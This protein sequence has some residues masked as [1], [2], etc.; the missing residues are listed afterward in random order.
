MRLRLDEG[1]NMEEDHLRTLDELFQKLMALGKEIKTDFLK[2]ANITWITPPQATIDLLPLWKLAM[3]MTSALVCS[4]I[5]D[6][7]KRHKKRNMDTGGDELALRE[8]QASQD[9]PNKGSKFDIFAKVK[10]ILS[11]SVR[12]SKLGWKTR[13]KK[14]VII[15]PI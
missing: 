13:I 4:K 14:K 15:Q 7:F 9:L 10:D 8:L 5:I 3:M 11:K 12:N 6:E 2:C 1:G